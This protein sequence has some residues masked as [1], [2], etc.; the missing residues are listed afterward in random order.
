MSKNDR[1]P[2][3]FNLGCL[4]GA[5]LR[6]ALSPGRPSRHSP[7]SSYTYAAQLNK[8]NLLR[9]RVRGGPVMPAVLSNKPIPRASRYSIRNRVSGYLFAVFDRPPRHTF[10]GAPYGVV[11]DRLIAT[12][13][14]VSG[15]YLLSSEYP[16]RIYP[17]YFIVLSISILQYS[18]PPYPLHSIPHRAAYS[19]LCT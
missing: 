12:D 7:P 5:S 10:R 19:R 1:E 17:S 4:L 6:A 16:T 13:R 9:G 11:C 15:K 18:G 8:S 14:M 3:L 2:R